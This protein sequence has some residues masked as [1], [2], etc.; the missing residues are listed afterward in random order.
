MVI[1]MVVVEVGMGD[2]VGGVEEE[3]GIEEEANEV[4]VEGE[5]I[6][7]GDGTETV[8]EKKEPKKSSTKNVLNEMFSRVEQKNKELGIDSKKSKKQE[9]LVSENVVEITE[10]ELHTTTSSSPSPS[11]SK[12]K[13]PIELFFKKLTKEE[14]L[15]ESAKEFSKV[16]VKEMVHSKKRTFTSS[17]P[18][19]RKRVEE[20]SKEEGDDEVDEEDG[21]GD[22]EEKYETILINRIIK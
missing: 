15:E 12:K 2:E 1:M 20:G 11:S 17:S 16:K 5:V 6:E 8:L 4:V 7:G 14:A 13:K 3:E 10:T 21:E 9:E 19:R 18:S 22:D